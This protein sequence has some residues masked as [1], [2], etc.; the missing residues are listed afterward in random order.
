MSFSPSLHEV[1]Q[2]L[3]A[4]LHWHHRLLNSRAKLSFG[5]LK[6]SKE[7]MVYLICNHPELTR[8]MQEMVEK[9]GV[10]S[11]MI[12]AA[13]QS[14]T[15]LGDDNASSGTSPSSAPAAGASAP[16]AA[17][18]GGSKGPKA[19]VKLSDLESKV[20]GICEKMFGETNLHML[21]TLAHGFRKIWRKIYESIQIEKDG[22]E[23]L[24]NYTAANQKT[25]LVYIPTHRSYIDFLIISYICYSCS[26][27]VP[28]IASG[29]DFLGI[30]L[31]RWMFRNS[32]A[33]F[34]RRSFLDGI[35]T[36][37]GQL[38][39]KIFE[40]YLKTLL[41]DGQSL[42]FYIEGTRSR[43]G[44]M[45]H[46]KTGML[47][48]ITE[49]YQS[50]RIPNVLFVP[51]TINYEKTIEGDLYSNE[52]LGGTKIKENFKNLLSSCTK[53]LGGS[54][55]FGTI[56][57][58]IRKPINLETFIASYNKDVLPGEIARQQQI[59]ANPNA[60]N[61]T[62]ASL[63]SGYS[64]SGSAISLAATHAASSSSSSSSAPLKSNPTAITVAASPLVPE[65]AVV[66][67]SSSSSSSS[68]SSHHSS[69]PAPYRKHFNLTLA[70]RIIYQ[71]QLGAEIMLLI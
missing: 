51:I 3:F 14:A 13:N 9:G 52:L 36:I 5:H 64:A 59:A 62:P 44:K 45:L 56:S 46:P 29:E 66:A 7:E 15:G 50:H 19:P 60:H 42:E 31:V 61:N 49:L 67:A 47:T 55:K 70:Y 40:L 27:P 4:D 53:F 68:S 22:L 20:K 34:I 24:Q 6:R 25:S 54:T 35:G 8:L 10:S 39:L 71:M 21:G 30:L 12:A 11:S 57:V 26:L 43:S 32:G 16:S 38:Y 23:Y 63:L 2:R 58:V 1:S 33:F 17:S 37:E 48:V 69:V 28:Y 41:C 65:D 18:S